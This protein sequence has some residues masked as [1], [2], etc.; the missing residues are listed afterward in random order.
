MRDT[1]V[2]YLKSLKLKNFTVANELPFAQNGTQLYVKNPK[3]IYVDQEQYSTEDF[4]KVM[5]GRDIQKEIVT[6]FVYLAIDAKQTNAE[7]SSVIESIKRA[8]QIDTELTYNWKE[9]EVNVEYEN[10]KLITTV[11]LRYSRLLS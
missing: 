11:E 8:K 6:V 4:M 5:N 3:T 1:I 7:Y 9:S 10:D 2:A